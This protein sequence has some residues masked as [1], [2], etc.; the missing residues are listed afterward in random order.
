M[1]RERQNRSEISI[2]HGCYKFF[3][4]LAQNTDP[5]W[6]NIRQSQ[7]QGKPFRETNNF[8]IKH[9]SAFLWMLSKSPFLSQKCSIMTQSVHSSTSSM[10]VIFWR[11]VIVEQVCQIAPR[12]QNFQKNCPKSSLQPSGITKREK[13]TYRS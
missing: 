7:R 4:I 1:K 3:S 9:Q 5:L 13:D 8:A 12:K 10:R 6:Q 11:I 2:A